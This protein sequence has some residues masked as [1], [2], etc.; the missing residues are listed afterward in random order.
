MVSCYMI[1]RMRINFMPVMSPSV[2]DAT[3]MSVLLLVPVYHKFHI[4][5]SV[6]AVSSVGIRCTLQ[7]LQSQQRMCYC[8][9]QCITSPTVTAIYT[10]LLVSVQNKS[11]SH[12]KI[13]IIVSIS[14]LQVSQSK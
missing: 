11:Y 2:L 9:Y 7:V 3:A 13:C 1:V 4:N 10:V 6:C 8:W 14:T 12:N 5:S